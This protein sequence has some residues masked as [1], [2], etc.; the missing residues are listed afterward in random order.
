MLEI[1]ASFLVLVAV[2][3]VALHFLANWRR[4]LGF[5][6]QDVWAV[7]V[8]FGIT[9]DDEWTAEQAAQMVALLREAARLPRVSAAAGALVVPYEFG[10]STGNVTHGDRSPE[11]VVNEVTDGFAETMGL[12]LVAGRWFGA[13]DDAAPS[14]PL[15]LNRQLA[16]ALFDD[17][18]P[19][20]KLVGRGGSE[21]R[22]VGV[23][24]DFRQLGELWAPGNYL[25]RRIPPVYAGE[26]PPRR[27]LLRMAPGTPASHER[28]V[29]TRLAPMVPAWSLE[30]APLAQYRQSRLR[31]ALAPLAVA[32]VIAASLLLMVGLGLLGVLWQSVTRRTRELGLRRAAGAS[33]AAIHRQVLTELMLVTTLGLLPALVLVVQLPL[34]GWLGALSPAVFAG[35]VATALVA[36]YLLTLLCGLYPSWIATRLEPAEAL[37]WE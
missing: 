25:F 11:T 29:L 18:D 1:A 15:V 33:R 3:A 9:S 2:A 6:W 13:E 35:A 37:R 12:R 19:I 7:E 30:V 10:M 26:R 23:I 31:F 22:V 27:L 21:G 20:G 17:Q 24:D 4:P 28:E 8:D 16:R 32:A 36:V 5:Q 34:L 14:P